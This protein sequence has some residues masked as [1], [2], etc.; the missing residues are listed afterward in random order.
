MGQVGI[1][2]RNPHRKVNPGIWRK[3]GEFRRRT[4]RRLFKPLPS[5]TS[6]SSRCNTLM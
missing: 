2:A 5:I 1:A 4:A 6:N 3:S